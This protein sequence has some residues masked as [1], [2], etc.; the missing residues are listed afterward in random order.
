MIGRFVGKCSFGGMSGCL[1]GEW[2][3]GLVGVRLGRWVVTWWGEW[4]LGGRSGRLGEWSLGG[5][6][7]SLVR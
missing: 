2:S 4:S 1:V 5:V 3:F 7:G 6:S